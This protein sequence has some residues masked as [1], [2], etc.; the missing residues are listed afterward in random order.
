[1]WFKQRDRQRD[2][3]RERHRD[4]QTH[5]HTDRHTDRQRRRQRELPL[6][7]CYYYYRYDY[8]PLLYGL[9]SALEQTNSNHN[10]T[11]N[12]NKERNKQKTLKADEQS[13]TN[14]INKK[15]THLICLMLHAYL[16]NFIL[17]CLCFHTTLSSSNFR[18]LTQSLYGKG[19]LWS[20]FALYN[21]D[22]SNETVKRDHPCVNTNAKRSPTHVKDPAVYVDPVVL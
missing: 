22:P 16:I 19:S 6:L 8:L 1:M 13:E 17:G 18:L 10:N 5:R 14:S 20:S 21:L 11:N 12:T 4:R 3:E 2:R 7:Y 15:N 9:F